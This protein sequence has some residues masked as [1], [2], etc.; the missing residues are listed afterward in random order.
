MKLA[1]TTLP[2]EGAVSS[3]LLVLHGL[4]GSGRN[5]NS[6]QK[7]FVQRLPGHRVVCP[8]LRNHGKTKPHVTSM[9]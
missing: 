9:T 6:L 2:M 1:T 5:W 3:R 4:L 7:A 8:D